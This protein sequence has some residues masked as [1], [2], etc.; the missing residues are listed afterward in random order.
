MLSFFHRFQ[1]LVAIISEM[2][3]CALKIIV[4]IFKTQSQCWKVNAMSTVSHIYIY[5]YI[6][7]LMGFQD[8]AFLLTDLIF[9]PHFQKIVVE[10]KAS[11]PPHISKLWLG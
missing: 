6:G 4:G 2:L 1:H 9:P 5:S 11:G 10:M 8:L 3:S 7:L